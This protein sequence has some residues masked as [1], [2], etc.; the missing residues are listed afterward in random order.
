M[1]KLNDQTHS[2]VVRL[3]LFGA[4]VAIIA[5]LGLSAQAQVPVFTNV[6]SITNASFP[7]LPSTGNNVRGITISPITTNVVFASTAGGSN[8]ISTL[9]YNDG[10][11]KLGSGSGFG[12]T[13]GTLALVSARASDDGF[14]YACNLTTSSASNFKVYRWPSDT[15]FSTDPTVAYETG[16][17]AA[18]ADRKG[19]YMDVRGSGATTEIVVAGSGATNFLL[20]QATD[21][22]ATNY[23]AKLITIGN[24]MTGGIT[25]EGTNNAIY[26]RG[27]D[28]VTRRFTYDP[29]AETATLQSSFTMDGT[30]TRGIKYVNLDGVE[31]VSA[32]SYTAHRAKIYQIVDPS[33]AVAVLDEP[34]PAPTAANANGI[35]LVDIQNEHFVFTEPNN[36]IMLFKFAGIITNTPPSVGAASGGGTFVEGWSPVT[37]SVLAGGTDP[38]SYQWYKD[39]GLSTNAIGGANADSY[40]LGAADLAD[41]ALY[42]CIVTNN[43]GSATSGVAGVTVLPGGYSSVASNLWTVAVGSRPYLTTGNTERGMAYDAVS[44]LVLVVS[45]T[46]SNMVALV[47][48]DTGADVGALDTSLLNA[49]ANPT[50]DGFYDVNM[51]GVADDG[52]IYVCNM[53]LSGASDNFVIYR[54]QDPGEFTFPTQAYFGNPGITRLGD[55]IAVRGSGVDTEIL[56]SFRTGSNV[57]LFTTIDGFNFTPTVMPVIN[58]PDDAQTG[59]FAGLGLAF[60]EANTFW[61]KSSSFNLRQVSYDTNSATAT[62]IQTFT[63]LT[64]ISEAPLGVDS[65]NG[66]VATVAYGQTPHNLS[67]WDVS[68]G[69]PNAKLADRELFASNN[70]NLN[71]TGAVA[72][73]VA[74]GRIFALDSNNGLL[75][76]TYAPKLFITPEVQ[77][78]IVTWS[79]PGAL[80]SASVVTGP[81]TDVIGAT[82]PY[83]NSAASQIYFRVSR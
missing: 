7:D 65:V 82:S 78:G 29:I 79:G 21:A 39:D 44:N 22:T 81:Y 36:G 12:I 37:L 40:D 76:A 3:R 67:L 30:G 27:S 23:T 57:C 31:L 35:G 64:A 2:P 45:R 4:A 32:V 55:T 6:W 38:L 75:A 43:Y 52:A 5:S 28:N 83:T 11:N 48:A 33:N 46:P 70:A 41:E 80:Q 47:D 58:L 63:N 10:Y 13:G 24:V 77:G 26:A 19:D 66:L 15:D 53:I 71:G 17:G 14:I 72:F 8:H 9:D 51:V 25:F 16:A 1:K 61:A 50:P 68:G 54:W 42:F 60:G 69:E 74:G 62:V 56:C 49:P 59:G 34:M 20:L 73:D 18:P